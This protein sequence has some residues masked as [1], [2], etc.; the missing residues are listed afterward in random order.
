MNKI[1]AII[2]DDEEN[3]RE[4][5]YYILDRYCPN[6]HVIGM[7]DSAD[8]GIE[9]INDVK[10]QLVFLDIQMPK[11]TG[12]DMLKEIDKIDFDV[13]F[14][15]S[16][17]EYALRAIKHSAL[18]YILKPTN[19]AE[20]QIAISKYDKQKKKSVTILK[21]NLSNPKDAQKIVIRHSKGIKYT[22][23][24]EI[25][26]CQANG[27]YSEIFFTDES[28]LLVART[29][30]EFEDLLSEY[31]FLRVHNLILLILN[32]LNI[33]LKAEVAL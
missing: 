30:K 28:S 21:E 23:D 14:V 26:R 17:D 31:N 8:Q 25:L 9:L 6:V 18:D 2:I 5:L 22:Y 20:L 1:T 15:T 3:A 12:F 32:M 11:K 13:I 7:A 10:P 27:N 19:I 24:S 16:F 29:L 33:T 4:G